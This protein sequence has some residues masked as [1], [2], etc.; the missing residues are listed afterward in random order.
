MRYLLVVILFLLSACAPK[1]TMKTQLAQA[2]LGGGVWR[3]VDTEKN[4]ACYMIFQHGI[5]CVQL[6]ETN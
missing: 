2:S 3:V 1:S 5:S 6:K 4:I